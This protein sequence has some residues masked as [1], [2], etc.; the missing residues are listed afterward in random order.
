MQ[1]F[2]LPNPDRKS[3]HL[4]TFRRI[5]VIGRK[6]ILPAVRCFTKSVIHLRVPG[7]IWSCGWLMSKESCRNPS[8]MRLIDVIACR[9]LLNQSLLYTSSGRALCNTWCL[10][11]LELANRYLWSCYN[12]SCISYY[13][14]ESTNEW[15]IPLRK[16]EK[17]TNPASKLIYRMLSADRCVQCVLCILHCVCVHV[18]WCVRV[19]LNRLA[20]DT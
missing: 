12:H 1:E 3:A 13:A 7:A 8:G 2:K 11:P 9:E 5:F 19:W 17:L 4:H 14:H 6:I 10:K 15:F 18:S 20:V 16:W